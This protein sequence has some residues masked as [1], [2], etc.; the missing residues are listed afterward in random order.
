MRVGVA[1]ALGRLGRVAA[2]AV[3]AADDLHLAA[4]FARDGSG[5]RL[6]E[7]LGFGGDARIFDS[8]DDFY[9]AGMDVV[10]DATVYPVTVDVARTAVDGG[11]SP[12]IGATGWTDEDVVS[13]Q[14]ACD[15]AAI[16]AM[17]IPN[18]SVGAV[19][20]MKLSAE[21][22]RLL[23]NVEIIEMHHAAKRDAP[24]GTAKLTAQR[25]HDAGGPA[26]VP[27]HSVRLPGL[28]A[29]QEVIFGGLGETLTIRHDS[30]ARESFAAGMLLAIRSVRSHPGLTVG[31]ESL[32]FPEA[33]R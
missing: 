5:E 6:A 14:D 22:V 30:L 29:H 24:S 25:L 32:L 1:G 28:V 13:F 10:L 8:L 21:V 9:A 20:M 17:L 15:E 19:L 33:Q 12:V 18:F 31:L 7:R 11:I 16:G 2:A 3:D 27:I 4:A 26:H 23:P